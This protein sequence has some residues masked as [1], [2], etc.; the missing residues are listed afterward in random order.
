MGKS[1]GKK[2][3]ILGIPWVSLLT[4]THRCGNTLS[5]QATLANAES[6]C[7]FKCPGN[8][9]EHCGAG[10]RLNLFMNANI[11]LPSA[12]APKQTV[13]DYAYKGCYTDNS[14]H[15]RALPYLSASDTMTI[16]LCATYAKAK[17]YKY[18]G[19]EYGKPPDSTKAPTMAHI[20]RPRMLGR[21]YA[22]RVLCC[23]RCFLFN[24]V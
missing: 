23:Q 14:S 17:G 10:S 11:V 6:E 7:S 19:V 9:T 15:G 18:F 1:A 16:E 4:E 13:G 21:K 8:A 22:E 24:A 3:V 20:H 12:P 5:T 2:M